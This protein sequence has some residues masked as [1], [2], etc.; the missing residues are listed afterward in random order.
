MKIKQPPALILI[1]IQKGL[2]ELE[3][4]G[5]A[6]NN[7]NAEENAAALLHFWRQKNFPVFH[8][9]HNGTAPSPLA[10]GMP[11]NEFKDITAP[12]EGEPIVEKNSNSAFINT[13]LHQKLQ[14]LNIS[15]L[16][17]VGLTTSH[18]V[19]STARMAG[20]FGYHTFVISDATATFDI[21]SPKGLRYEASLVHEITL[22]NLHNEF[23]AVLDTSDLI[24]LLAEI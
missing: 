20:N 22:A 7:P 1:D 11:G 8:I 23:A 6:R 17:L 3:Y 16:V 2:E 10:K 9:K 18:C 12:Q 21:V 15:H 13:P 5:G 24:S 19:S 14:D 4:Y